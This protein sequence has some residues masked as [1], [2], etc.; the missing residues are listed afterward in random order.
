[1]SLPLVIYSHTDF[2]DILKI[3]TFYTKH[4][5]NKVLLINDAQLDKSIIDCFDKIIFYKDEHPYAKRLG[6]LREISANSILLLHDNDI[7]IY[8]DLGVIN[9]LNR[10]LVTNQIDRIDLQYLP[11]TIDSTVLRVEDENFSFTLWSQTPQTY[12]FNVNPSI[13]KLSSLMD[14]VDTFCDKTY[15]NIELD[16]VQ[17]YCSKYKIFKLFHHSY[18]NCGYFKC[19][20]FFVFLHITHGGKLLN[21]NGVS[22]YGH[23]PIEPF[24]QKEYDF[25]IKNFLTNTKREF[26]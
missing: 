1:M 10:Y 14:I 21:S 22:S 18:M 15:R 5:K 20:P 6:N 7:L 9:R 26:N 16:P 3:Q 24:L 13:W 17:S 23:P 25:I 8:K 2:L 19:L 11:N 12:M 4:I